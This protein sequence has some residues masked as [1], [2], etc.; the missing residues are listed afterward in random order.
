MIINSINRITGGLKAIAEG[1]G[2]LTKRLKVKRTDEIGILA[3]WF[4]AFIIRMNSIIVDISENAQT[5]TAASEE[6]L[7]VSDMMSQESDDLSVRANTVAAATEEMSSNM[8]SVAAASEQASTNLSIVVQSANEMKASLNEVAQSCDNARA[9]SKN[10]TTQVD[11]AS[12]K[13]HL[14]GE[15]VREISKVTETITEIAAQTNL[16]A[17]NATIEAARAGE[18]GKGFAVVASEI[19]ALAT[20][21][22]DATQDIKSKVERIQNSTDDTV[23]EVG[24]ISQVIIDVNEIVSTIAAAIEEQSTAAT[25]V[26]KN[27]DQASQGIE[28]VNENVAQSSEVASEIT[29]EVY[30]VNNIAEEMFKKSSQMNTSAQELSDLSNILRN[31][32]SVFKISTDHLKDRQVSDKPVNK[33]YDLITWGPKLM[34]GIDEIDTQ[35]KELVR[36]V[37]ELHRAM[38]MR[39]GIQKSGAILN[40]LAE[41]TVFHFEYEEKLFKEHKYPEYK[42]HKKNHEDLVKT[43]LKFQKD[44]LSGEAALTVDLMKF[45]TDWL[46][47][48]IMKTDMKYVPFLKKKG[49]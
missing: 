45:L 41:Y 13:V 28:E 47:N 4:N 32:I 14:L 48:H 43:V 42:A 7:S 19:K 3:G 24:N 34:T 8:N 11:N 10:A 9:I 23:A 29:K 22:A 46:K 17:L 26:S 5:V 20:Q 38:K 44:F 18:A 12:N 21:T 1:K 40:S 27:I 25:E 30:G 33:I 16:L 35:H 2:D 37:N 15:S 36:M 6:V 39:L 49:L 31:M